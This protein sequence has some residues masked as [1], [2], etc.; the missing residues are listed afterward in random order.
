[1][2]DHISS[3]AVIYRQDASKLQIL[4]MHR[5]A[6]NTWHLPKGT[7]EPGESIEQ[8]A[9]REIKEE[10]G[11]NV[12][13]GEYV[14]SLPSSFEREGQ[15]IN[16]LTHYFLAQ[17]IG[18]STDV[19]DMEH[20]IVGYRQVNEAIRL[21]KAGTIYEQEW[22]AVEAATTKLQMDGGTP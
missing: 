18:G 11:L 16:K 10:T 22:L 4:I 14:I 15:T 3:G 13:L 6:T 20:D 5:Y 9:V 19:H 1:M 12:H 7:K 17:E 2:A 8:T 21:L